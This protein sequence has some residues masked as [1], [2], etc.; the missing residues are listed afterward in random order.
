M[1]NIEIM[2][3]KV[4]IINQLSIQEAMSLRSKYVWVLGMGQGKEKFNYLN[5][6][7]IY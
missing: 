3:I 5:D 2:Y 1:V 6:V 4:S 7:I